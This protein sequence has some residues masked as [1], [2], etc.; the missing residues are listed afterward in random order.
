MSIP[1]GVS[2][3]D[4]DAPMIKLG[5]FGGYADKQPTNTKPIPYMEGGKVIER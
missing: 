1:K 5:G 4:V 2:T 3:C